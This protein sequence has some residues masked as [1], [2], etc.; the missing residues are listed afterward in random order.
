M[1][2]RWSLQAFVILNIKSL[3]NRLFFVYNDGME[4][5]NKIKI[6]VGLVIIV[7]LCCSLIPIMNNYASEQ[8]TVVKSDKKTKKVKKRKNKVKQVS[9][10]ER[11]ESLDDEIQA[12][13]QSEDIDME[14]IAYTICDQD[15]GEVYS[16]NEDVE[17]TAASTY[18]LPLAMLYYDKIREG[19]LSL[20]S[21]YCYRANMYE[22]NSVLVGK[23]AVN[24][25]IPLS[26]ILEDLIVYSDN[27]AGHIL[28]E[29]LG[30]WEKFK[31]DTLEYTE[32]LS[33]NYLTKDN[34][35]T[36]HQ[37]SDILN[38][39]YQNKE[40]YSDLIE[41]M[42]KSKVNDY[43]DSEIQVGMPQKYGALN[44]YCNAAGFVE[45]TYPYTIVVYT[46]LG[47]DGVRIMGHINQICFNHFNELQ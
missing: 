10:R 18:K 41:N 1:E 35:M 5:K 40:N 16:Y 14:D 2:L 33:E 30:G 12:Y 23:Y 34:V 31:E 15:N 22:E 42:K 39:L 4:N 43:L 21:T 37:M 9:V 26:D 19:T 45:A 25:Q 6:I 46:K 29:Y 7:A 13:L 36:A 28:F 47:D 27:V 38:H 8:A 17:F 24:T 44:A 11:D 3:D 20:E 32:S